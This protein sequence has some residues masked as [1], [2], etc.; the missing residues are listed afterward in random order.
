MMG[1]Y[2]YM[3]FGLHIFITNFALMRMDDTDRKI[4]EM[5]KQNARESFV[6]IA[7]QSSV[8]EGTVRNRVRS[9]MDAGIIESFT[10][11][12][13][14]P[15][16]GLVLIKSR[17]KDLKGISSSLLQ[18]SDDVFE[19]AGEYDVACMISAE[20]IAEL[21]KKIDRIRRIKDVSSTVTAI[22]LH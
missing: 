9:M 4:I 1:T 10:I 12:C 11:K 21:N 14:R 15:A 7:K 22:K 8:S 3:L 17:V 2:L 20:S 5:L 6:G 16:E 19:V 13:S 18:F